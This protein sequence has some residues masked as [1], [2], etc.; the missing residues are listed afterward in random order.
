MG[1]V[2]GNRVPGSK[3]SL[4]AGREETLVGNLETLVDYGLKFVALPGAVFSLVFLLSKLRR[5]MPFVRTTEAQQLEAARL[6]CS[7]RLRWGRESRSSG[8]TAI[9]FRY[10]K[11]HHEL[12]AR[13]F[14]QIRLFDDR[15]G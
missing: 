15:V 3:I 9:H 1:R 4:F 2:G 12:H 10:A 11:C 8:V 7:R 6:L 5:E 14:H 13:I